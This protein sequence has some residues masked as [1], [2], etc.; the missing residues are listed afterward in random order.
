MVMPDMSLAPKTGVQFDNNGVITGMESVEGEQVHFYKPVDP[1]VTAVE[2]WLL[3]AEQV[4][5]QTLHTVSGSALEAYSTKPRSEW[6]LDWPGQLVLNCSQVFWTKVRVCL[7]AVFL[8]HTK[9]YPACSHHMHFAS[10]MFCMCTIS[11]SV[12]VVGHPG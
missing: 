3:E 11:S 8:E 2:W 1:N 6:I 4:I 12:I 9:L 5:K 10:W 7:S